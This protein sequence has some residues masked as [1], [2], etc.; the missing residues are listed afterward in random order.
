MGTD[1]RTTE[2]LWKN[3]VEH[4][5]RFLI[6]VS[7][8][9]LT[10]LLLVQVITAF[11]PI[12]HSLDLISGEFSQMPTSVIPASVKNETATITLYLAPS[13]MTH[14]DVQVFVNGQLVGHFVKS[15]LVIQC[16]EGDK[17]TL[18]TTGVG[19]VQVSVDHNDPNLL[20]PAP[21]QAITIR[22]PYQPA[23]LAVVEFVH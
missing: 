22:K 3:L 6:P 23:Q 12:R 16:R 14:P 5:D 4:V 20:V 7:F 2:N 13:E 17:I 9:F 21:G 15:S 1:E 8:G 10:I 19:L 18:Q 11:P